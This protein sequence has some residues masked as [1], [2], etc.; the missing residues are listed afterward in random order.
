[1]QPVPRSPSTPAAMQSRSGSSMTA[2]ASTPGP[3]ATRPVSAGARH[4][5]SPP[6]PRTSRGTNSLSIPPATCLWS[7]SSAS[8]FA[9]ASGPTATRPAAAGARHKS[10]R[11]TTRVR[12]VAIASPTSRSMPMAMPSRSGVNRPPPH[13]PASWPIATRQVSDGARCSLSRPTTPGGR[14]ALA[15]LSMPAATRSRCGARAT[16]RAATSGATATRP[17]SAGARRN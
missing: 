17:A 4:N 7:G 2:C 16:A 8:R 13:P 11:T 15:S 9:T 3:T 12:G 1:M 14:L 10:S 5:A 6:A